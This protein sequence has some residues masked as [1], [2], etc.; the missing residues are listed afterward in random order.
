MFI[1]IS[2]KKYKMVIS[3]LD[4][5]FLVY[6]V[7]IGELLQDLA[8]SRHC[9]WHQPIHYDLAAIVHQTQGVKVR[10]FQ[11]HAPL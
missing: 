9:Q 7:I 11:S 4:S 5:A 10:D 6:G 8:K 1:I 3:T 2:K